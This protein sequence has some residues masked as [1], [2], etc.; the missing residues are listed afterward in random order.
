MSTPTPSKAAGAVRG[1]VAEIFRSLQGEG[2]F[3]GRAQCFVRLSGCNLRCRYCD[4]PEKSGRLMTVSQTLAGI[5]RVLRGTGPVH[6]VS[7]TGGEPLL[8]P[9]FCAALFRALRRRGLR[10]YLETNGTLPRALEAVLPHTD[11]VAMDV[12]CP[13][14]T[15]QAGNPW[16]AHARFLQ[17]AARKTVFVKLVVTPRTLSQD[18]RR[19]ALLLRGEA[20]GAE[21]YLQPVTALL[22]PSRARLRRLRAIARACGVAA[23]IVPQTHVALQIP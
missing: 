9:A 3:L 22:Q 10:T 1:R 2:P 8:Q 13:S 6:S 16:P 19:A 15:Q 23:W 4:T 17:L 21:L 18:V 11:I 14:S 12:K 7:L 20:A 5:D